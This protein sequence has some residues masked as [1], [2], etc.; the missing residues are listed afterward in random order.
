[1]GTSSNSLFQTHAALIS[2]G[3]IS[4]SS[5]QAGPKPIS[6]DAA[7][8]AISLLDMCISCLQIIVGQ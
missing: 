4:G 6:N 7:E 5:A 8:E 3:V 1:V 2:S